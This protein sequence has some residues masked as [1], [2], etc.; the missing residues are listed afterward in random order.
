MGCVVVLGLPRSGTSAVAGTL[1]R[2][3]VHMGDELM[4]AFHVNPKGFYEDMEFVRLHNRLMCGRDKD[5]RE[6]MILAQGGEA[7]RHYAAAIAARCGRPVWGVKDPKLCFLLPKFVAFAP[8]LVRV[9]AVARRFHDVVDSYSR[10]WGGG[11][12]VDEARARVGRYLY[13]MGKSLDALP[14]TVPVLPLQYED[15]CADPEV[16]ARRLASFARVPYDPAAAAFV[17][18][19]LNRT[20]PV[21][22]PR[23]GHDDPAPVRDGVGRPAA[24]PGLGDEQ[25]VGPDV[26]HSG[27]R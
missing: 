15:L 24:G 10:L 13:Q 6:D 22:Q 2:L 20:R 8:C 1:H 14:P 11:M 4:P 16:H 21:L 19:A 26:P 23:Q 12:G 5:P 17:D 3:G 9:V 18:P 27:L 25:D 7:W